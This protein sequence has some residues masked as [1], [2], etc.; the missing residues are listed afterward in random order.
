M[1]AQGITYDTGWIRNGTTSIPHLDPE[2][3]AH[4]LQIIRDE[5]HCN[6]VR[7][8][9]GHP[10]RLDV[11][12]GLAVGLGLEVWYSP[13]PLDLTT[14]EM[15]TLFD[16]CAERAEKLRQAGGEIVFVAGA[17]LSLFAHGFLPGDTFA[18]RIEPLVNRSPEM[19]ALIAES[20]KRLDA[21]FATAVPRIRERFGGR[22]TYASIQLDRLDWTPFDIVSIDLY[23]TAAI[24]DQFVDGVRAYVA[25]DKPL[26]I[27]EFG[28]ATFAGASDRGA[29]GLEIVEN[30]PE[31]GKPLRLD[32][33][34]TRDEAGQA[35]TIRD[36]LEIF[37]A[38]GVDSA[39]VFL[40]ALADHPHRPDGDP[41]DDL[42]LASY[43]IVRVLDDGSWEPKEAF[44]AIAEFYGSRTPSR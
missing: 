27:T 15:L 30:D 26:A 42:D 18:D 4:D 1:R 19:P 32:G 20:S 41:R 3:V 39:F 22:V 11:A 6:T 8:T 35:D 44:A 43:G 28:C 14:D 10:D 2:R 21:F 24:A 13:Y 37:D 25:M 29:E 12:A 9:G 7:L 34:Y 36:L 40:F 16:D 17:E 23:R 38:E 33:E 31:T 5:L